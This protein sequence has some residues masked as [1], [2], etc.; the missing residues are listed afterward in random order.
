MQ[1]GYTPDDLDRVNRDAIG[2]LEEI[3][4]A[5]ANAATEI[6]ISGCVGPRGDAYRP[7]ESMTAAEA[8]DKHSAQTARRW[9]TPPPTW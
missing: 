7:A 9:R 3:R 5:E 6:V 4:S 2:L 1:L 8:E